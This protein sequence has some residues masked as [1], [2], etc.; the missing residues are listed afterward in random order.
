[1]IKE[2]FEIKKDDIPLDSLF[3]NRDGT[4]QIL[5]VFRYALDPTFRNQS[6]NLIK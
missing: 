1:M 3:Y 5:D 4:I 2:K 6:F